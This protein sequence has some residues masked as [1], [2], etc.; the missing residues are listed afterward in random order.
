MKKKTNRLG[1]NG[2]D[3]KYTRSR[4]NYPSSE[5]GDGGSGLPVQ[6]S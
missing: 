2:A 4:T 6:N 3:K 5:R 1:K